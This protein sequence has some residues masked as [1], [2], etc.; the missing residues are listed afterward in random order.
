MRKALTA[1]IVLALMILGAPI[2]T[3]D[4][5]SA[6]GANA[7][8]FDRI[9]ISADP[10]VQGIGG[11]MKITVTA[12]FYGGCCY[13]L[14]A[15][16][17]I[18]EL[19]LPEGLNFSS[20]PT[21]EEK[22]SLTAVAGGE[23]TTCSFSW[24]LSCNN[25][26]TFDLKARIETSDCGSRE[27]EYQVHVIKGATIS[28]LEVYPIQ[29]TD[30]G[31]KI[32][33]SS[34]D[35]FLKFRARYVVG[36]IE[37]VSTSVFFFESSKDLDK[38]YLFAEG[39]SIFYKDEELGKGNQILCSKDEN[40]EDLFHTSIPKTS[41]DF[42]YYWIEVEDENQN[43]TTSS[44]DKLIIENVNSVKTWNM[45]SVIFLVVTMI[46]LL[47]VLYVGQ[48]ILSKRMEGVESEDKFSVLGPVGRK[49]YLTEKED[50]RIKIKPEMNWKYIVVG[51]II[52][53]AVAVSIFYIITGEA[54]VLF[55]HF[56]EGK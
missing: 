51:G 53:V 5:V 41:E 39:D 10:S 31:V 49:R 32:T 30:E 21:P 54:G 46:I 6:S 14:Y 36:D 28:S 35:V 19:I 18:P 42:L 45:I 15:N 17:I 52:I 34:D 8:T 13:S 26:G 38:E 47:A 40:E 1:L 29:E 56:L 9:E 20:G 11:E 2:F 3:A 48:A 23:P 12:Y 44:V 55:E 25:N 24:I 7:A 16:D 33:P 50:D 37:V 43:I 4:K 22:N 27:G